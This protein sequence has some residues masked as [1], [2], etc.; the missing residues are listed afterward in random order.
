MEARAVLHENWVRRGRL[1][2]PHKSISGRAVWS[3]PQSRCGM[4]KLLEDKAVRVYSAT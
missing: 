3:A 2:V 1:G 4:A